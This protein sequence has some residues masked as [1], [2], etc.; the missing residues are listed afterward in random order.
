MYIVESKR[1]C[2]SHRRVA[3]WG[4]RHVPQRAQ[5]APQRLGGRTLAHS[6]AAKPPQVACVPL[7]QS[8]GGPPCETYQQV[9]S[10]SRRS[11]HLHLSVTFDAVR[12]APQRSD[13]RPPSA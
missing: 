4:T 1:D 8:F 7:S 5:R 3:I 12:Y 10:A 9:L 2:K 13:G 11:L 6:G